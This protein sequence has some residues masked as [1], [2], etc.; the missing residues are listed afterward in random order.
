ML[1][2]FFDNLK[3]ISIFHINVTSYL[4]SHEISTNK[5]VLRSCTTTSVIFWGLQKKLR[6]KIQMDKMVHF[7]KKLAFT[8]S[9]SQS[10]VK[11]L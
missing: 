10:E 1:N 11:I 2:F 7:K 6:T 8:Y 3:L 5:D 9:P 4:N